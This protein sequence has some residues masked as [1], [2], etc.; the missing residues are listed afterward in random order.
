MMNQLTTT[1]SNTTIMITFDI[2]WHL[3][4]KVMR[5]IWTVWIY[6][7]VDVIEKLTQIQ[8]DI[9]NLQLNVL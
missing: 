2:R 5:V 6:I 1:E 3:N 4:G 9:Y 8:I 7:L